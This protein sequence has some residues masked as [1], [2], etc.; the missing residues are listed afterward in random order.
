MTTLTIATVSSS[1]SLLDRVGDA[2][3]SGAEASPMQPSPVVHG[4]WGLAVWALVGVYIL[5]VAV[6]A[7]YG[8]HR[9]MLVGTC[10]RRRTK[11]KEIERSIEVPEDELPYVTIQLPL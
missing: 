6:L 2:L 9:G 7:L 8:M 5:L 1:L 11:L 3:T 10:L 4:P